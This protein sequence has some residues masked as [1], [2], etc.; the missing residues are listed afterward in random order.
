MSPT[1]IDQ[2]STATHSL[3]RDNHR[4]A[5]ICGAVLL[6]RLLWG[7]SAPLIT[8]EADEKT[9]REE[10]RRWLIWWKQNEDRLTVRDDRLVPD[11]EAR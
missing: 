7:L 3:R 10:L 6:E 5:R 9:R 1:I 2:K 11:S 4:E 8:P